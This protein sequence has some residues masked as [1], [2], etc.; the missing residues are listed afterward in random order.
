[1]KHVICLQSRFKEC[2]ETYNGYLLRIKTHKPC[3]VFIYFLCKKLLQHINYYFFRHKGEVRFSMAP[4]YSLLY[5]VTRG[6]AESVR[7]L[8]HY[9]GVEFED[10]RVTFEE[11]PKELKHNGI[12]FVDILILKIYISCN[13]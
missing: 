2:L 1:M 3:I 7:M 5:F 12:S 10:R 4:K 6:R 11:F 8:F 13:Y 9:A